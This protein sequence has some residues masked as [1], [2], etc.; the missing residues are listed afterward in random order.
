MIELCYEMAVQNGP[1]KQSEAKEILD[2]FYIVIESRSND[3]DFVA[4][5]LGLLE[6]IFIITLDN[7]L[8][9]STSNGRISDDF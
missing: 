4:E 5:S 6:K 3:Q 2:S 1:I 7:S 9:R 8:P